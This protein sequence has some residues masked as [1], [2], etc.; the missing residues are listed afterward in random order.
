[1]ACSTITTG[2][3]HKLEA[4]LAHRESKICIVIG[5]LYAHNAGSTAQT[6]FGPVVSEINPLLTRQI[7]S[8]P[9]LLGLFD[10]ARYF[11]PAPSGLVDHITQAQAYSNQ[12]FRSSILGFR[13]E[14]LVEMENGF[15]HR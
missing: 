10:Q 3:P 1:V 7:S 5:P 11:G 4:E 8:R 2:K 9:A 6:R 15:D 13:L 14:G 12:K